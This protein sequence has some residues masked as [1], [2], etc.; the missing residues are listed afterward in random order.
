MEVYLY[1]DFHK[2]K[3]NTI[4]KI[5]EVKEMKSIKTL[6]MINNNDN[7][8]VATSDLDEDQIEFIKNSLMNHFIFRDLSDDIM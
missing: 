6:P 8:N 1:H 3:R 7:L 4:S 2:E 5:S